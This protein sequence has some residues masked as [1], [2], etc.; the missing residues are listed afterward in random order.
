MHEISFQAVQFLPRFFSVIIL[1]LLSLLVAKFAKSVVKHA[2]SQDKQG[3]LARKLLTKLSDMAFWIVILL[4]SPFIIGAAGFDA[5]WLRQ[6][7][8]Y[9][10]QFFSNWPIW[11]LMSVVIAGISYLLFNFQRL[12]IQLK[13]S[14]GTTQ[15]KY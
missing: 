5:V 9:L 6:V 10:G 13:G 4:F 1:L 2:A 3:S 14:P 7:Y 11:I 8:L 12:I 15:K